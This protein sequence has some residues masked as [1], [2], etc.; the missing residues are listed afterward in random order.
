MA[1]M[2]LSLSCFGVQRQQRSFLAAAEY[3]FKSIDCDLA[4][5]R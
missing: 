3:R 1:P 2:Q 4:L 5:E